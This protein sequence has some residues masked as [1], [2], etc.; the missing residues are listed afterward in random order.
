M[1]NLENF[2]KNLEKNGNTSLLTAIKEA[3]NKGIPYTEKGD[4]KDF[5]FSKENTKVIVTK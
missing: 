2:K 1:D 3:E 5:E 4:L